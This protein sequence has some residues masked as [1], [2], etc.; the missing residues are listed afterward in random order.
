VREFKQ[1][2]FTTQLTAAPSGGLWEGM[3]FRWDTYDAHNDRFVRDAVV[4]AHGE[5]AVFVDHDYLSP[6]V[7]K[8]VHF[9]SREDGMYV[10][11]KLN[12]EVGERKYL[13]VGGF[14]YDPVANGAGGVD[15]HKFV[16]LEASL[17]AT[18]AQPNTPLL[19]LKTMNAM[20]NKQDIAQL[21]ARVEELAALYAQLEAR[22]NELTAKYD[23][24][25]E[26]LASLL[27]ANAQTEQKVRETLEVEMRRLSQQSLEF[28]DKVEKILKAITDKKK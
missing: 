23:E 25:A 15:I 19:Q 28:A 17:T 22:V 4:V 24:L 1:K 18:P 14:A 7:G 3:L 10:Y 9:S 8:I 11:L 21:E 16:V 12:A 20:I 26:Q 27:Q 6:P 13:S 5:P 2:T